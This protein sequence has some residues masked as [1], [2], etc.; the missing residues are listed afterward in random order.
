M[1]IGREEIQAPIEIVIKKENP[2][3]QKQ[4]ARGSHSL[5]NGFIGEHE[6]RVLRDVERA[7]FVGEVA[8]GNAERPAIAI[9]GRIEAHGAARVPVAVKRDSRRGADFLE[10]SV[11]LIV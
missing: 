1:A 3:L 10:S 8:D 6:W 9:P 4:T 7:H 5:W 2:E 11:P